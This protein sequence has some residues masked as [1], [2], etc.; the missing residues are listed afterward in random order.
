MADEQ[1][2][3]KPPSMEEVTVRENASKTRLI[4]DGGPSEQSHV[5]DAASDD[6]AADTVPE[7]EEPG[8]VNSVRGM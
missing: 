3:A 2:G 4:E 8:L 5:A 7:A 6:Q 1:N